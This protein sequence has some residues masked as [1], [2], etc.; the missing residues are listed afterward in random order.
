M[1]HNHEKDTIG[2]ENVLESMSNDRGD[3]GSQL[4]VIE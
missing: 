3:Q 4:R 2:I 1:Q